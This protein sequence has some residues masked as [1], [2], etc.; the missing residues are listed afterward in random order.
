LKESLAEAENLRKFI[1]ELGS[2]VRVCERYLEDLFD[3]QSFL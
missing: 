1:K 3:Y 2:A